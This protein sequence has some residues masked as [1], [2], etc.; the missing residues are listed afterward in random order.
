MLLVVVRGHFPSPV[1]F[2]RGYVYSIIGSLAHAPSEDSGG[3]RHRVWQG[4]GLMLAGRRRLPTAEPLAGEVCLPL[5]IQRATC[6]S[7]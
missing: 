4:Q 1:S 5:G 2:M 6:L 3:S 7:T